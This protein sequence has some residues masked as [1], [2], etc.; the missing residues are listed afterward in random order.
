MLACQAYQA[1]L[2]FAAGSYVDR[3]IDR[4]LEAAARAD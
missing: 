1:G 3:A 4:A 2:E